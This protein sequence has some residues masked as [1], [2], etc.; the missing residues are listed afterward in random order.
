MDCG[1]A[2]GSCDSHLRKC[3]LTGGGTFQPLGSND[4]T[5][6]LVAVGM[7]D[8]PVVD[9]SN[10][11]LAAVFCVGPTASGAVNNVVGLPGPGRVTI[12]GLAVG[13]P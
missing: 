8:P 1:G 7:E 12:K 11:T 13:H 10:P 9:V 5:D 6:S 2:P 4:G 3:F